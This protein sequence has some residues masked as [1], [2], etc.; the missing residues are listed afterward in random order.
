MEFNWG[1]SIKSQKRAR[2]SKEDDDMSNKKSKTDG[3]EKTPQNGPPGQNDTFREKNHVHFYT[4]VTTDSV[5]DLQK[6]IID[7]A[8]EMRLNVRNASDAGLNVSYNPIVLH[9]N[10]FGGSLFA[11][12]SFIGFLAQFKTLYPEI[13]IRSVIDGY[14]ASAATLISVACDERYIT[15]YGYMLIH[16]LASATWG[17]YHDIKDTI[18]NLDCFMRKIK[19][20]Y[21]QH[22]HIK[23]DDL[24]DILKHDL[25]WDSAKCEE[26]GLV[27]GVI[28]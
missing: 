27:D 25:F 15:E 13:K 4:G 3:Y 12:F 6:L 16:Q 20:I 22:T 18:S 19:K 24:D 26:L 10:S 5:A 28:V 2:N 11:A 14:A 23:E 1:T 9:I 7:A 8:K 17:K 21:L